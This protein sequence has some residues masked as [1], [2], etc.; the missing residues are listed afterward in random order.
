MALYRQVTEEIAGLV[1]AG[2]LAPGA[3]LPS[4]RDAARCYNTTTATVSRAYRELADAGVIDVHDR[5]RSTVAA[6][7]V[8]AARR[9]LSGQINLRLAGSDDPALDIALR[10][11]ERSVVT[12]GERGSF[13]GLTR[14]WRGTADAAAIHLPH[15]SGVA[16]KPFARSVLR[17]RQPA[18]IHLW[19]RQQGFLTPP[20]NPRH[21]CQPADVRRLTIARRAFGTGTRVLLDQV[22][23]RSGIRPEQVRGPEAGSHLEVAMTVATGQADTG[24]GV[25]AAAV[26]LDLE[27]VPVAWEEFD[28]ILSGAMLPAAEPLIAALRDAAV[29]SAVA[30]LGGYDTTRTGIVEMLA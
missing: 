23:A 21:I 22:L 19:R 13:Q 3:L 29:Q 8:V 30:A 5:A 4:I 28:V 26:A 10:A 15:R 25:R 1:E 6:G 12:I 9:L 17:D 20:G 14:L 18:V 2:R 27:F 16:N 11:T 24:L 7:G